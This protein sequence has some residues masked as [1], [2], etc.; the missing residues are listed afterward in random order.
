MLI[1]TTTKNLEDNL[2]KADLNKHDVFIV[3][4]KVILS[5]ILND[6]GTHDSETLKKTA[7]EIDE[8]RLVEAF[9]K[10]AHARRYE[11]QMSAKNYSTLVKDN[12]N[13]VK[14]FLNLGLPRA[15][16]RVF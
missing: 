4:C 9:L 3:S 8:V 6:S 11:S 15:V 16:D 12:F 14:N 1:D 10:M 5:L 13:V 2:K 7:T